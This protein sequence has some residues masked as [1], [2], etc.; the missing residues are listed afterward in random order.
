MTMRISPENFEI[1]SSSA[2]GIWIDVEFIDHSPNSRDR[3]W[4]LTRTAGD[5]I[6]WW[7]TLRRR[8]EP[9]GEYD[10][11]RDVPAPIKKALVAVLTAEQEKIK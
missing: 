4:C 10:D 9:E 5:R 2:H 8:H 3:L 6:S 11:G 1:L 7:A